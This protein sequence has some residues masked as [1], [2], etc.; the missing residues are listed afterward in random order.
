MEYQVIIQQRLEQMTFYYGQIDALGR[1]EWLP[2]HVWVDMSEGAIRA[3]RM[4]AGL[5]PTPPY[6]RTGGDDG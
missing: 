5:D 3:R 1:T 2:C 6:L 4:A